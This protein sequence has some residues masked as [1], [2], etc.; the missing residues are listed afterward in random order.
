MVR[1]ILRHHKIDFYKQED[2]IYINL[3]EFY[4]IYTANYNP[5]LFTIE[6][7]VEEN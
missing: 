3:K 7:K 6:E 4:Q 2:V 5:A 1:N